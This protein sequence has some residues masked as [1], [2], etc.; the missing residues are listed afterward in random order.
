M[1]LDSHT[2]LSF[3]DF[4]TQEMDAVLLRA[5]EAGVET[6][7]NIGAGEGWEGNPRAVDIAEQYPQVYAT[8]GMHPHDAKFVTEGILQKIRE[9]ARHEKVVALGEVGLD[10]FYKN[11]EPEMQK[12][13]LRQQIALAKELKLPLSVHIRDAYKDLLQIF[14]EEN[15]W[16]A[17]GV[18]HCF[19][20]DWN[21]ARRVMDKGFN[22]SFSGIVTFKKA[23][24]L[25]EVVRK[26][27]T[28]YLMIETDAPFLAPDPFRG[29]RNEPALIKYTAQKIAELKKL[30]YEDVA[31]ISTLNAKRLFGIGEIQQEVK[32][33][34]KI[35]NSLYLNITNKCTLACVFCP[36]FST[37][38]VKGYYLRLPKAP[39]F[40]EML[41]AMG[42]FS[43]MDEVVFCG[44]GESTQRLDLLKQVAQ[45][46][47]SKGKKVRLDTDGLGNLI[48]QRN[49]C[50]ELGEVLDAISVSMN[51]QDAATYAKVCPNKYKEK[52]YE[53]VKDFIR[54]IKKYVPDVTASVVGCP[55]VDIAA[56]RRIA[57]EE[58]GV[59]FRHREYNQVG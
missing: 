12:Q 43:D 6:L 47:K 5:Q 29:K 33:A 27:P 54:E 21:F 13:A 35:R 50:P 42:D 9:L 59:K 17:R 34:Y 52:A 16:D 25:Q 7:I 32:L 53:A 19:S 45:Y 48:H 55:G 58:L 57:E 2:H 14:E 39:E 40:E 51:A 26:I 15:A 37:F 3:R 20:G 49:I 30:S 56:A 8:V 23:K 28:E 41:K 18:I 46:A 24:A 4:K 11:S 22:I 10:F 44:F 1:L 36:K 31:R 38:E